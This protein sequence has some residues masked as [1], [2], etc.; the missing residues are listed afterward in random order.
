MLIWNLLFRYHPFYISDSDE[1]GYGQK[2]QLKQSRQTVYAGVKYEED[3]YPRPTAA[4]R[5]CE[6][7]HI[8][9]D[10]SSDIETFEDYKKTLKLECEHGEPSVLNWTVS[11]DTP[12]LVYYQ[13]NYWNNCWAVLLISWH[14]CFSATRTTTLDGKSMSSIQ[15]QHCTEMA[16][17]GWSQIARWCF[18]SAFYRLVLSLTCEHSKRRWRCE[19]FND[20]S[21]F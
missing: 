12:D 15:A 5:Y 14:S 20:V 10:K 2:S 18:F 3:G 8:T 21:V 9:V 19:V 13:V 6:W 1:G 7:Q 4:G 17:I 16:T 11:N